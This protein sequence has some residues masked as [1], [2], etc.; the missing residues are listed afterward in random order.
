MIKMEVQIMAEKKKASE[1]STHLKDP[2]AT[3]AD[4]KAAP[5]A[6]A[7]GKTGKK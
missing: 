5:A 6:A 3:K 4:K 2:K 1:A 7:K